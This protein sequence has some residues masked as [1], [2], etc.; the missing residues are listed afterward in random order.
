MHQLWILSNKRNKKGPRKGEITGKLQIAFFI[1]ALGC[2]TNAVALRKAKAEQER[3]AA[4][5]LRLHLT[6]FMHTNCKKSL[7][8]RHM[9]IT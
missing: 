9:N 2:L 4:S 6:I 7:N 1:L 5:I 3:F 8:T